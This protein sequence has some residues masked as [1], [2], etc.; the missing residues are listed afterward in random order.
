[1]DVIEIATILLWISAR[2][3][4]WPFAAGMPVVIA[5]GVLLITRMYHRNAAY[6]CSDLRRA[7]QADDAEALVFRNTRRKRVSCCSARPAE[8]QGYCVETGAGDDGI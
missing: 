4:W 6:I 3:I 2:G 7:L 1:M 8:I 5:D